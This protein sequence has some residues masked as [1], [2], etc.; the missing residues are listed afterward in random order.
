[1]GNNANDGSEGAVQDR[2]LGT[3]MH[4]SLLPKNPH[5][6]DHLLDMA[7]RRRDS[8]Y[9]LVPLEDLEEWRAHESSL[10]LMK[11]H[12]QVPKKMG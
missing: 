4:G 12:G 9:K 1:M 11:L 10:R 6:A 8:G 2:V 3:Y 7:T 5:F